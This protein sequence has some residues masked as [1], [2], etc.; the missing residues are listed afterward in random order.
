MSTSQP[1]C[2]AKGTYDDGALP[3]ET[4]G[5]EEIGQVVLLVGVDEDEVE[6]L[7]AGLHLGER[8]G[9]RTLNNFDNIA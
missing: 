9:S 5:L 2:I 3:G 8:V 6:R 7:V 1:G 4:L